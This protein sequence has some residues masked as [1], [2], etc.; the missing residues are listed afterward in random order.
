[1]DGLNRK[2]IEIVDNHIQS[3]ISI[4][5]FLE[6]KGFRT[7]QAYEPEDAIEMAK[8]EKPDLIIL[9]LNLNG[10]SGKSVAKELPKTKVILM[11]ADPKKYKKEKNIIATIRKPVDNLELFEIVKK[12]FKIA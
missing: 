8:K 6:F 3:A 1:M 2:T 5:N 11:I 10:P 7:L 12:F 9:D 4:S